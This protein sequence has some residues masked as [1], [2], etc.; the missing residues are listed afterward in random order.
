M[1]AGDEGASSQVVS[2]R[3]IGARVPKTA[4]LAGAL[5]F[6]GTPVPVMKF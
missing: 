2:E 4:Y 3:S 5:C 6:N 1:I